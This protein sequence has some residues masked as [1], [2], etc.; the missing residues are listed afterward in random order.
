MNDVFDPK[1]FG[2]LFIKHTAEHY[3]NYLMSLG[4]LIGVLVLGIGFFTYINNDEPMSM[5]LQTGVFAVVLLLAGTMFTSTIFSE[6]GDKKRSVSALT[7]PASHFEKYLVAWIYSYVLFQ[8]VFLAVYPA[9]LALIL[10]TRHWPAR[11]EV[12]NVFHQPA[13]PWLL[14]VYAA[15]HA[16]TMCGAIFFKKLHFIKTTFIFFI[17][18]MLLSLINKSVIEA[19]IGRDI[20]SA[21]PFAFIN[22][23]DGRNNYAITPAANMD[24]FFY[25]LTITLALI[26]WVAAY[27]RLTEK[28]V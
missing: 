2:R 13:L 15:L 25:G 1:R 22:F 26:L 4:V 3:K 7:L 5:P 27:F 23:S 17:G 21:V 10:N 8:V 9:I 28:Q 14:M 18:L 24:M 6:M 20:V 16:G 11:F 19:A 12:F